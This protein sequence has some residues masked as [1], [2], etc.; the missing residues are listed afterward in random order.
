MFR[1]Y[2]LNKFLVFMV[3]FVGKELIVLGL[4][5]EKH[6]KSALRTTELWSVCTQFFRNEAIFHIFQ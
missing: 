3:I 6:E 4:V 5:R 1:F 2:P